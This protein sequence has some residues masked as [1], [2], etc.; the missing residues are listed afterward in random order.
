MA[1]TLTLTT[2]THWGNQVQEDSVIETEARSVIDGLA[3]DLRQSYAG[4][5]GTLIEA[6]SPTTITFDSPDRSTPFRLRRI[7][8][9]LAG[10]QIDRQAATSSNTA[11]PWTFP[12]MSP[13]A[14]QI[15]SVV[16]PTA[17]SYFDAS[18]AA[19][20]NVAAVQTV[21]IAVTITTGSSQ[22][23]RFTYS[24]TVSLRQAS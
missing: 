16:S 5:T 21:K 10:G 1:L 9:R 8:Y 7:S 23:R 18:G 4:N 17:F 6:M 3:K 19:T 14:R 2:T 11:A 15:G 12:A 20:T 13:W 22:G 24:S